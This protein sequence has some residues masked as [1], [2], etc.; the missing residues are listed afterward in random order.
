[1]EEQLNTYETMVQALIDVV[2]TT[3]PLEIGRGKLKPN[4]H[5]AWE[6]HSNSLVLAT[7]DSGPVIQIFD[8]N[9]NL[10]DEEELTLPSAYAMAG[11][12]IDLEA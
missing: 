2:D 4:E 6:G 8:R 12:F 5:A 1:M 3:V 10:Q 11:K 7:K 9:F